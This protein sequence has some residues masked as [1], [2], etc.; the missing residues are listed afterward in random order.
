MKY[1]KYMCKNVYDYKGSVGS[2]NRF[3]RAIYARA[4]CGGVVRPFLRRRSRLIAD[5]RLQEFLSH[6]G[7][8]AGAELVGEIPKLA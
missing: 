5:I 2:S 6:L 1:A 3:E 4:S 8:D 7:Y